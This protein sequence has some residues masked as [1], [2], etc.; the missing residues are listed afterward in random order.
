MEKLNLSSSNQEQMQPD[1]EKL[2]R[3]FLGTTKDGAEVYDRPDSHFHSEGGMTADLLASALSVIDTEGR[4]F[5]KEKV[6][7]DHPIGETTCVEVGPEDE[8]VMVYR[9]GRSGQTPMVKNREANPCSSVVAILKKDRSVKDKPVYELVT[10]YIGID[11]PREPW[12]PGI[13]TEEE[14]NASEEYWRTHAIIYDDSLIDWEKTKAFEFMSPAEKQKELIRPRILYAGLFIDPNEIYQK[15]QPTLE[16]PI[17]TPHVT[18]AFKPDLSKLHFDQLGSNAK[19]IAVGYGND[20]KN[21]GLLVKVEADDPEVQAACDALE[22][23][24]I[25]LSVSEDGMAKDTA[26]LDFSPLEQPFE[27]NGQ[28]GLFDQGTVATSKAD[29]EFKSK[30]Y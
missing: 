10:S 16:E 14:K 23:P 29:L 26:F 17:E 12:D 24:H 11:S 2:E 13:S 19:I 21:E 8:I 15:A 4:S 27:I 25:T 9:K 6:D 22:T 18:T 20:G 30:K 28:Y 1:V 3:V 5:L 7:F